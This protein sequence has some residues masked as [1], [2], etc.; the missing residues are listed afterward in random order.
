MDGFGFRQ[1]KIADR[2]GVQMYGFFVT[3]KFL[4]PQKVSRTLTET[5]Q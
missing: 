4:T 2:T 5:R 1:Y 3:A